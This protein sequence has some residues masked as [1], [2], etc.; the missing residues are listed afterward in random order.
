VRWGRALRA[1][2]LSSWQ[3]RA[4][5]ALLLYVLVME[6]L[7]R[8]MYPKKA[9]FAVPFA[10]FWLAEREPPLAVLCLA[11][12]CSLLPRSEYL[13]FSFGNFGRAVSKRFLLQKSVVSTQVH[14][15][16]SR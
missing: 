6:W 1:S 14:G 11:E 8:Y 13:V 5:F 2:R 12:F 10:L 9:L 3:E 15:S 7:V 4:A 16:F